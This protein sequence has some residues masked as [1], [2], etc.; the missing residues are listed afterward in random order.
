MGKTIL[1]ERKVKSR[2]AL[3]GMNAQQINNEAGFGPNYIYRLWGSEAVT[4]AT[5]NK[6]ASVLKCDACDL[7]DVEPS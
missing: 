6:I 5:I 2:A 7:L 1:S 3:M 4:L